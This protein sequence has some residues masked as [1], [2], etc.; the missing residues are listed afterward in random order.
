M[1]MD[2]FFTG[3]VAL[4]AGLALSAGSAF[5]T[6]GYMA[7]DASPMKLVP[8]YEI[9]D[10]KATIIGVQNIMSGDNDSKEC[11]N[12]ASPPVAD[13]N[14]SDACRVDFDEDSRT[15]PTLPDQNTAVPILI[16]PNAGTSVSTTVQ[17]ARANAAANMDDA[18]NL[19]VTA[20]AYAPSGAMQGS[21]DICLAPG[22][23]GYFSL[24]KMMGDMDMDMA[25]GARLTT[26]NGL[27]LDTGDPQT[28]KNDDG[29]TTTGPN[30]VDHG[31]V[32]LTA[33]HRV[34]FCDCSTKDTKR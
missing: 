15:P 4:V 14:A 32:T 9:G 13:G 23:F 3:L 19:I 18:K 17:L 7:G 20:I 22:A 1:K 30:Y 33:S 25:N 28:M 31:Y 29:T 10:T 8:H 12:E 6:N 2:R 24:Q 34:Q 27:G 16:G 11:Q 5:A 26:A 21:A